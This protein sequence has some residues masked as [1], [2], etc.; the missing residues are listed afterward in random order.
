M[1]THFG[2]E[3]RG[4]WQLEEELHTVVDLG[5]ARV[6]TQGGSMASGTWRRGVDQCVGEMGNRAGKKISR[7]VVDYYK[8]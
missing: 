3:P 7:L 1:S 5:H 8:G 6:A 2:N 4:G